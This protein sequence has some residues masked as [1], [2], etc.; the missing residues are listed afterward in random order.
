MAM[1][2]LVSIPLEQ[3]GSRDAFELQLDLH[4]AAEGV[5]IVQQRSTAAA[6][7]GY[8]DEKARSDRELS[9]ERTQHMCYRQEESDGGTEGSQEEKEQKETVK[10]AEIMGR[11][12]RDIGDE[13]MDQIYRDPTMGS[14]VESM[15]TPSEE[16]SAAQNTFEHF[17]EVSNILLE[18]NDYGAGMFFL[19]AK[20]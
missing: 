8:F 19:I 15:V 12:I 5:T 7:L 9:E 3:I 13:Y 1:S 16:K 17:C 18:C 10:Y 20:L 14:Y 4:E 2:L 11:R 6:F